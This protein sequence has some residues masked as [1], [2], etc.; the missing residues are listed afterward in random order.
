MEVYEQ[1]A[2]YRI[3]AYEVSLSLKITWIPTEQFPPCAYLDD[4]VCYSVL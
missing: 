2:L 3:R 1:L 4:D